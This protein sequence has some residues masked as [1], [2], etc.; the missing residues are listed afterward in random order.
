MIYLLT[1]IELSPGGGKHLHTNNTQNNTNINQT[2][3][4]ITNSTK[5]TCLEITG[6]RIKYSTALWLTELQ[7]RCGR[8][9]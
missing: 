8:N 1:A 3:Q 9:V 2:T 6:Y 7:I 5:P 4:I